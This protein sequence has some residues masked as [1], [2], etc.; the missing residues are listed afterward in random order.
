VRLNTPECRRS[1]PPA[2]PHGGA[3]KAAQMLRD[4]VKHP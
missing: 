1:Q 2:Q 4:G 3:A